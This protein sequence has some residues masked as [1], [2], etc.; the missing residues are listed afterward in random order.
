MPVTVHGG[1]VPATTTELL[2]ALPDQTALMGVLERL[3][4]C[5]AWLLGSECLDG[6]GAES[7][8]QKPS[9]R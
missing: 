8:V 9:V 7:E 1:P 6:P 4:S 5:G 3:D 2:G